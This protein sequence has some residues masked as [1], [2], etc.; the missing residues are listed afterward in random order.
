MLPPKR[1]QQLLTQALQLQ[2]DRCPFHYVEQN[3][4]D[5]SLLTDHMCSRYTTIS[6]YNLM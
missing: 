6:T 1:L 3:I 5:Y 2:V 4:A